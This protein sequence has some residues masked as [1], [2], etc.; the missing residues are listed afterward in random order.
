LTGIKL[1]KSRCIQLKLQV[2][3]RNI[4]R[5][6]EA[7]NYWSAMLRCDQDGRTASERPYQYFKSYVIYNLL[8]DM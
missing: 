1:L 2:V 4:K 6:Y 3:I 7:A 5:G 8:I